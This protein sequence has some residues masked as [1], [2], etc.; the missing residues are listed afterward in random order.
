MVVSLTLA[1][2]YLLFSD[3][4]LLHVHQL[5]V[6]KASLEKR[7]F[8][9]EQTKLSVQEENERLAHSTE[10]QEQIIREQT[11]MVRDD[12]TVFVF[13]EERAGEP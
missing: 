1:M 5:K 6:T 3:N 10:A 13:P 11:G 2:A 4:G 12:E 9:L 7:I 8:D